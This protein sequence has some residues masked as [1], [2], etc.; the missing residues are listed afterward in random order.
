MGRHILTHNNEENTQRKRKEF[1]QN[2]VW[3]EEG[4][5]NQYTVVRWVGSW[6]KLRLERKGRAL[7][8]ELYYFLILK[9]TKSMDIKM[10]PS[11]EN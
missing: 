3:S 1:V 10:T 8:R 9:F 2:T 11:E 7:V 6:C 4:I 5:N